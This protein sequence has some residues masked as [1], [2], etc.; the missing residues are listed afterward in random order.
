[1]K[2]NLVSF[3]WGSSLARGR[4]GPLFAPEP[5]PHE[6]ERPAHTDQEADQ[7][8]IAGVEEA[9]SCPADPAPEEQA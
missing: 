9:V 3:R 4:K 5:Q 7:G 8:E 1:M 2:S 6:V